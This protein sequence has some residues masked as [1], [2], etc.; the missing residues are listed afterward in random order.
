MKVGMI[1]WTYWPSPEGGAERQCRK[2]AHQLS[3]HRVDSIVITSLS[4]FKLKRESRDDT[5]IVRRFGFLCPCAES[6]RG[7]LGHFT[8]LT[9]EKSQNLVRSLTFWFML[10]FE[11][12]ARLSFVLEILLTLSVNKDQLEILHVHETA[13]LS[14]FASLLGK[15]WQIPVISKVR[16]TPALDVIG[17]DTPFRS[18]WLRL[19]RRSFFIALNSGLKKELLVSGVAN[20][21]I[22]IIPNG[23]ELPDR[24]D[25]DPIAG[26]VVY[27][28]NFSQG[29][30]HKGFDTL[31]KAWGRVIKENPKAHLSLVGGGDYKVWEK[32]AKDLNCH[33][34]ITFTG[35]V[36]N[37]N[38][39]YRQAEVFVLPSRHEGMSNALLEAQGWGIACVVSDI[40]ANTAI[41]DHKENGLT[42]PVGDYSGMAQN[43]IDVLLDENLRTLLGDNARST[44]EEFFSIDRIAGKLLTVYETLISKEGL[45]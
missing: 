12:L 29:P 28:G 11:W 36:Q 24:V 4:S 19:R 35:A 22:I 42:F 16:N 9:G 21:K 43:I 44:I 45:H 33:H 27:V 1:I 15:R 2:M 10:P 6:V 37:P 23:V 34:A 17:Y 20:E 32:L 41:V 8:S 31:I 26:E 40:P 38:E 3:S 7:F 39:Y 25:R 30:S 18:T 14:G 13:W 5:I